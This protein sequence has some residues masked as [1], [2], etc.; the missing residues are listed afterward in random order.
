VLEDA[1]NVNA[2]LIQTHGWYYSERGLPEHWLG[3][4]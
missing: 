2:G 4:Q 3:D 1:I